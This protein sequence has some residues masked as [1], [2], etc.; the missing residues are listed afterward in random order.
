MWD[1][2]IFYDNSGFPLKINETIHSATEDLIEGH[3]TVSYLAMDKYENIARCLINITIRGKSA[4]YFNFL[5]FLNLNFYI[6]YL[7][8]KP[9]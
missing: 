5:F 4:I 7:I 6:Y 3:H 9:S 2:P 8:R 1:E